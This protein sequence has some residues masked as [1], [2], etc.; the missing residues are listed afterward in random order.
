LEKAPIFRVKLA[1][2][3]QVRSYFRTGLIRISMPPFISYAQ[4]FEDVVLWRALQQIEKGFYV[5]VGAQDPDVESVTRAFYERG[6]SG[7]NIEPVEDYYK[8]LVQVRSRDI[9]LK[10]AAGRALGICT[11]HSFVGSG[12]STLDL[13]VS[14]RHQAAGLTPQETLVPVL[15]LNKILEDAAASTIHF[16]KIDVEGAEGEV[17]EGIDLERVRPWIIVVEA[18]EPNIAQTARDKWEGMV[19]NRGYSFAYFDGLN[20]F[21]IADEVS[22]LKERL[23]VPPNFFDNFVRASEWAYREKAAN[24]EQE[25]TGVRVQAQERLELIE[26]LARTQARKKLKRGV[27]I[28]ILLIL[29]MLS[30]MHDATALAG[31]SWRTFWRRLHGWGVT[32]VSPVSASTSSNGSVG[33]YYAD[34][35][36]NET[37]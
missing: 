33:E 11:L 28:A 20:C 2:F 1:S 3:E 7:I 4:N 23:S 8:K 10:V 24:L 9:N 18:T 17:L 13:E 35:L 15:T 34:P 30:R 26:N 5:D 29:L 31:A 37:K 12:L 6:W 21:Y 19:T 36:A 27:T 32:W 22:E 14:A 16:L 25:L